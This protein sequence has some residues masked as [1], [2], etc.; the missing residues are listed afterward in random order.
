[1]LFISSFNVNSIKV[2]LEIV[3]NYLINNNIDILLLQE[4]K[5]Q[6]DNFPIQEFKNIGYEV[7]VNGQKSYNGVAIVS[8]YP[9]ELIEK[10]IFQNINES[11]D[12]A[13]FLDVKILDYRLICVYAPNGNPINTSKYEFKLKWFDEFYSYCKNLYNTNEK[14]IIGGDFNIIQKEI[15][16]YNTEAWENDALFSEEVKK[17][18]KRI[19]NIGYVDSYR[20]KNTDVKSYSFWDYQDGAWQKDHGIRIDLFLLSPETLDLLD[21]CGIDK[22]LR[23]LERPSDHTAVWI[24][25][26]N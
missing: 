5:C 24:K 10:R 15:D 23:A 22:N 13:R 21:D 16:C 7:I 3:K 18:L 14:V 8:K 19:L 26:K 4:I 17:A 2:R 12:Q 11:E 25:L 20:I 6:N 1:M 9:I